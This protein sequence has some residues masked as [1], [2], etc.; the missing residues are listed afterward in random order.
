MRDRHSHAAWR[1]K[2]KTA[3]VTK[4]TH[5]Q[6]QYWLFW[7]NVLNDPG[8]L[9]LAIRRKLRY[10]FPATPACVSPNGKKESS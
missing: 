8:E 1:T 9:P 10:H 6:R 2:G 7:R 5:F 3:Y 4:I